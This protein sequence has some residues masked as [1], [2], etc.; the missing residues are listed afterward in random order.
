MRQVKKVNSKIVT[1]GLKYTT[2]SQK[3]KIIAQL[4]KEQNNYCA[5]TEKQFTSV[6]ARDIEHFNPNLKGSNRDGYS[7]WY[8]VFHLPNQKKSTKWAKYQP[9]LK[10]C[11]AKIN[12]VYKYEETTGIYKYHINNIKAHN[13]AGLTGLNAPGLPKQRRDYIERLK[14]IENK[15]LSLGLTLRDYLSKHPSDIH[16]R[17]A[18]ETVF[19]FLP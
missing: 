2:K 18:I 17:T 16:F 10:P 1:S 8:G 3:D 11:S 9:C 6:D 14:Y 15:Q 7:N 12:R 13:L 4:L 19:G 5:Y